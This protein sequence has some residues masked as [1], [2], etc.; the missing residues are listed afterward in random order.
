MDCDDVV[1]RVLAHLVGENVLAS[2]RCVVRLGFADRR[3]RDLVARNWPAFRSDVTPV[4]C[5][6]V[7][8][9]FEWPRFDRPVTCKRCLAGARCP[10]SRYARAR[11]LKS[12]HAGNRRFHLDQARLVATVARIAD[13]GRWERMRALSRRTDALN[14]AWARRAIAP[15]GVMSPGGRHPVCADLRRHLESVLERPGASTF[16]FL[17]RVRAMVPDDLGV[18]GTETAG[19]LLVTGFACASSP[20]AGVVE[21]GET[22]AAVNGVPVTHLYQMVEM[23]KASPRDRYGASCAAVRTL[24]GRHA[25]VRWRQPRDA[26]AECVVMCAAF[27]A[28]KF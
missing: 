2:A 23:V 25:T 10:Q 28:V 14:M 11:S 7:M 8:D 1:R 20:L 26:H 6:A 12:V 18:E 13:P 27:A 9:A 24:A 5:D 3:M 15:G 4:R 22:I 16:G 17:R 21:A 19:G